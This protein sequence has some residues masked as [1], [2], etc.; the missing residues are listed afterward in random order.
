MKKGLKK[1]EA[2][3]RGGEQGGPAYV[4][5]TSYSMLRLRFLLEFPPFNIPRTVYFDSLESYFQY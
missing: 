5:V 3:T 2:T 4:N 1:N